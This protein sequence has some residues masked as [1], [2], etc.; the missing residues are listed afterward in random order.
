MQESLGATDS[1][2]NAGLPPIEDNSCEDNSSA[3]KYEIEEIID[4]RGSGKKL[5]YLVVWKGYPGEDSWLGLGSLMGCKDSINAFEKSYFPPRCEKKGVDVCK[6]G[7]TGCEGAIV[8]TY[9]PTT[10]IGVSTS[11]ASGV[12]T[13]NS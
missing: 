4:K 11:S 5:E 13:S 10:T 6:C 8:V 12:S 9:D 3:Q 1:A 7:D 2:L